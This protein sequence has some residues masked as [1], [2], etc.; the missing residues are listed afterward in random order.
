VL[1]GW[2]L[3]VETGLDVAIGVH[4]GTALAVVALYWREIVGIIRGF[5]RGILRRDGSAR[6]AGCLV[7]TS[8]P[9]A[10]VGLLA[11]DVV[12]RALAS[13][14]FVGVGLLITGAVLWK[15]E[16][17]KGRAHVGAGRLGSGGGGARSVTYPQAAVVGIAQAI[18]VLPGISRSGLTISGALAAGLGREFAAEYSFIASLPVILG[19]VIL[20]PFTSEGGWASLAAPSILVAALCA[21]VSGA[22]AMVVLRSLVRRGKLRYFS[23]YVWAVGF[24]TILAWARGMR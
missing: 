16:T 2:V 23:Y 4:F 5:V 10:L 13:P 7:V 19:G 22:V 18:A 21:A 3:G 6:L 20:F 15:V 17:G 8:I 12:D 24:V 9:A 1:A 14:A 11:E